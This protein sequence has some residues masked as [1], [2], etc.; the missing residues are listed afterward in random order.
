MSDFNL[1]KCIGKG[2]I[3]Q[4]MNLIL[5]LVFSRYFY[6]SAKNHRRYL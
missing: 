1:V 2:L 6:A 4:V 5:Y 3:S